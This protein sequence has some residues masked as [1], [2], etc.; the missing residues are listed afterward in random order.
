MKKKFSQQTLELDE[1]RS[2]LDDMRKMMG[3]MR[4]TASPRDSLVTSTA[5]TPAY[6]S[7]F[8]VT[9]YVPQ[10]SVVPLP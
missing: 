5:T 4:M 8:S 10:P 1:M 2:D 9:R 3:S 6:S 7:V